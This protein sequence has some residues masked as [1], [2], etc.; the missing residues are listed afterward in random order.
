MSN[1]RSEPPQDRSSSSEIAISTTDSAAADCVA[2]LSMSAKITIE[3]IWTLPAISAS[4]PNSPTERAKRQ[5]RA[6]TGSQGRS[7]GSTTRRNVTAFEAPSEAAACLDLDVE[8]DQHRLH[9]ARSASD[10]G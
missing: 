10:R 8:L 4:A 5:R 7:G 9:R 1:A 2:P 3:A 6:P